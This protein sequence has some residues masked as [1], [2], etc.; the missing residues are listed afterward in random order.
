MA[1]HRTSRPASRSSWSE[2]RNHSTSVGLEIGT[3][4]KNNGDGAFEWQST[5]RGMRGD[6]S[7]FVNDF[8]KGTVNNKV[9]FEGGWDS[10]ELDQLYTTGL[11]TTDQAKRVPMYRRIQQPLHEFQS[12]CYFNRSLCHPRCPTHRQIGTRR[13]CNHHRKLRQI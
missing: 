3:F 1:T 5:G 9:W 10:P 11:A 8:F 6:V 13:M 2:L 4:A 12:C 7:G